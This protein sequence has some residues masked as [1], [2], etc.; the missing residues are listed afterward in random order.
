MAIFGIAQN[1]RFW[2]FRTDFA[3]FVHGGVPG[4]PS[5]G[6]GILNLGRPALEGQDLMAGIWDIW[7]LG[8]GSGCLE[9][10]DPLK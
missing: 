7:D 4:D 9:A 8:P 5:P 10:L 6:S 2:L 3:G 1:S